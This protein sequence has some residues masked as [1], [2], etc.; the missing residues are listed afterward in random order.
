MKSAGMAALGKIMFV[1]SNPVWGGSEELWSESAKGLAQSGRVPTVFV[2][3]FISRNESNL[4]ELSAAGCKVERLVT[5]DW[6][7]HKIST[8]CYIYW[9]FTKKLITRNLRR[10]FRKK[11]PSLVVISQGL[12]HDGWVV[13]SVCR[14][15]G[16]PYVLIS[17][18]ADDIYWPNDSN[19]P[20][21][22]AIYR[23]AEASYFVSRHN[24]RT[25]EEQLGERLQK[26]KI[27]RNPYRGSWHVRS[28]W[29]E[30][31][32]WYWLA[33]PARLDVREKGQD[34]LLRVL[35]Q[36]K[37]KQRP[38][39]VRFFGKGHNQIGLELMAKLLDIQNVEFA[40]FT[41]RPEKIWDE[42]QG[43][44][45][46]SRCEGLPLALV[47][48]MM[49]G[50]VAIVCDTGGSSEVVED[51][52][53]GFLATSA[54]ETALDE[55]LE[56]AWSCRHEWKAMGVEASHCIRE[57]IPE[58]PA[59]ELSKDLMELVQT[60]MMDDTAK[61]TE[62]SKMRGEEH[63]EVDRENPARRKIKAD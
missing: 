24:L 3:R 8:L 59:Y 47:E 1:S 11:R 9:P 6:V 17:Q 42:H 51:N 46:P 5:P 13:A 31:E 45:L 48:G 39:G 38:L 53:T 22:R 7:P 28:K 12:N 18:K 29:P 19:L 41:A 16:V 10:A 60:L 30:T 43:L 36:Q 55:A 33:C 49:H 32:E 34:I 14:R 63:D 35:S 26:A 2:S 4:R 57:L 21:L 62:E 40:G 61:L 37:W 58:D 56:R 44:I 23:E 50:R 27:V 54:S 25:T 52:R 20:E 15:L